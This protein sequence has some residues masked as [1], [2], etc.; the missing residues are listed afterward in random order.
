MRTTLD[1]DD[2]ILAVIKDIA[3]AQKI[4]AGKVVSELT[5]KALAGP[6]AEEDDSVDSP[7][8]A[9]FKPLPRRSGA[10]VTTE[11]VNRLMHDGDE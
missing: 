11:L 7:P 4:S 10:V 2:D 3:A 9:G 6:V 8:L 1:I 5:R